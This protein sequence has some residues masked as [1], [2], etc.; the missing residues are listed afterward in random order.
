M[1]LIRKNDGVLARAT[2]AVRDSSSGG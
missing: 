2:K 1:E